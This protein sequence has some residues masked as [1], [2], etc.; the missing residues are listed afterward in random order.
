MNTLF[1]I[2]LV[3]IILVLSVVMFPNIG[4]LMVYTMA[5]IGAIMMISAIV[6]IVAYAI[7]VLIIYSISGKD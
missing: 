6:G 4:N 1:K 5:G 7:L 2:C 3:V